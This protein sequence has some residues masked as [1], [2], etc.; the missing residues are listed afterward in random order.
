[1]SNLHIV[2]D[3]AASLPL[4][5]LTDLP[6][7]VLPMWVQAGDRSLREGIDIDSAELYELQR[8]GVLATTSQPSPGDF[9]EVFKPLVEQGK[10]VLAVLVTAKASGTCASARIAAEMLPA[11]A[12]TVFDSAT[13][14][15]GTGL[16]AIAAAE[17]ARAGKTLPE[18]MA[19][20]EELRNNNKV[21]LAAPTL[22]HLRR[23]GRVSHAQAL[24]AGFLNIKVVLTAE[25]GLVVVGEKARSWQGA[26]SKVEELTAKAGE[27]GPLVVAVHHTDAPEQAEELYARLQSKVKI[28]R[29]YIS[30]LSASLAV[31]G[32]PGMLG[33]VFCPAHLFDS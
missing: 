17:A 32:G 16:Q 10:T 11:G 2:T 19:K 22:Q 27:A 9:L 25:D 18:I 31:H 30:E 24:L 28:A 5:A 14:A 23:S 8:Q 13:T 6:L 4:E 1:M 20:L 26:V 33:V 7:T 3:S 15:M 29:G 21:Y 12:V